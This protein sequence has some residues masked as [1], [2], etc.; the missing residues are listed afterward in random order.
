MRTSDTADLYP[1]ICVEEVFAGGYGGGPAGRPDSVEQ[2]EEF[3]RSLYLAS[4]AELAWT[5]RTHDGRIVGA[6]WMGDFDL[7][8]ESTHLGA[9]AYAPAVWGTTVNPETKLLIL[10]FA[11]SRGFGRVKIQADAQNSRSRAAIEKLGAQFEGVLRRDQRRADGSWRDTA[12]Y[13]ILG[14]EW[15]TIQAHLN[16]RLLADA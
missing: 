16:H 13:S 6:V 7:V 15:P 2:F 10:G 3:V 9:T 11:F 14:S 12:V 8:N 1:A 5:V 4:T